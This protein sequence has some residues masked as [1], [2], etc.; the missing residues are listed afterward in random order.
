MSSRSTGF[1][2][3]SV[4]ALVVL[5]AFGLVLTQAIPAADA[6]LEPQLNEEA[7]LLIERVPTAD[8]CVINVLAVDVLDFL[9]PERIDEMSYSVGSANICT[10]ERLHDISLPPDVPSPQLLSE[11]DFRV[12]GGHD[13][14]DLVVTLPAFDYATQTATSVAFDLHWASTRGVS[15]DS[16]R[17]TGTVTTE[18]NFVVTLDDSIQWNE[19]GSELGF[20]WAGMWPCRFGGGHS[21]SAGCIG[22]GA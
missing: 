9:T 8:P 20:P 4:T 16:F 19:W 1:I 3:V 6:A 10:D 7:S 22:Q 17:V 13:A 2:G 18:S 11:S 15:D 21:A 12:S 5:L 14:G